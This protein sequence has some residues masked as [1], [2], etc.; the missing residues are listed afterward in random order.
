MPF[1]NRE[2][3][4]EYQRSYYKKRNLNPKHRSN[5]ENV[6]N[7]RLTEGLNKN[8]LNLKS[9]VQSLPKKQGV[10]STLNSSIPKPSIP[11]SRPQ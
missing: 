9:S 3:Y 5:R 2:K 4:L 8:I 6:F 7:P 1:K 10:T 11:S